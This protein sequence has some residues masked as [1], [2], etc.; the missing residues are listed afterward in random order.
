MNIACDGRALVGPRTGVGAWTV[1][2]CQ[3]LAAVGSWQVTTLATRPPELPPQ[4]RSMGVASASPGPCLPGTVWLH[5]VVPRWLRDAESDLFIGSLAV[6]PRRCPVPA[7]AVIHDL[8]PR[9]LAHHHTVANR[10]CFNAYLEF[11]LDEAEAVVAVSRATADGL[12]E[13]FPWVRPKLTVIANAIDPAFFQPPPEDAPTVRMRFA[14]GRPYVLHLGT[15]EPRKGLMDLLTAWDELMRRDPDGPDLVLAGALGWHPRRL[16]ARV[17]SSP[18]ADR[19]HRPGYVTDA[20]ARSLM[21]H[22]ELF[23]L[24]SEAEG[25]GLPLAEALA[26]GAAC[27][28][29]DVPA[30]REVAGGAALLV[31]PGDPA[32]LAS[33]MCDALRSDENTRLRQL[34]PH[35]AQQYAPDRMATDWRELVRCLVSP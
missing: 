30:L 21:R 33:A 19:I 14:A 26:S 18:W 5:T 20:D 6:I 3:A 12:I 25:F 15:L 31:P 16:L 27:V 28:A 29:S 10:F 7:V 35:R 13:T 11:S 9:T 24:A 1:Q 22:S 23:V 32:A 2:L 34:G 17:A 8:T 4:L